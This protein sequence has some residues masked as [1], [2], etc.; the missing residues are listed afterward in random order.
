MR[1]SD[2]AHTFSKYSDQHTDPHKIS[3]KNIRIHVL[4]QSK[5]IWLG[6]PQYVH[7]FDDFFLPASSN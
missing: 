3:E 7:Y 1:V 5:R 2:T 4:S 6:R